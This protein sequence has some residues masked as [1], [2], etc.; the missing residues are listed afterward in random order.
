MNFVKILFIVFVAYA[1][2]NNNIAIVVNFVTIVVDI[3]W[4]YYNKRKRTT[5]TFIWFI[6]VGASKHPANFDIKQM[7]V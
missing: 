7:F 4:N 5:L 1:I 3:I 6:I 2:E